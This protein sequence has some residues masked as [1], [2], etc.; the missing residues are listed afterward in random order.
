[1]ADPNRL[2]E[3]GERIAREHLLAQGYAIAAYNTRIGGVE[4]DFIA[5]RGDRVCFVE[6]KTRSTDFMDPLSTIDTRKRARMVRAADS[7]MKTCCNGLT[8]P[9]PLEPQ[10]DLIFIIGTPQSYTIEHIPD[11]FYPPLSTR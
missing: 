4:I 9:L 7:Y 10:F 6:V 5:T 1:M 8:A 11:A 2:G 3:W